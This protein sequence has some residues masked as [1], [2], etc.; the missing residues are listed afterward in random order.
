[1]TTNVAGISHAATET[2]DAASRVNGVSGRIGAEVTTLRG[3]VERFLADLKT[4]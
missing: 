1:M 3:E 4:A 2:G